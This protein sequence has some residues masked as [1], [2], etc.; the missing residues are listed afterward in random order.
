M[1]YH[2]ELPPRLSFARSSEDSNN[3]EGSPT[4]TNTLSVS[5]PQSRRGSIF[6][7]LFLLRR[8]SG[9]RSKLQLRQFQQRLH[10]GKPG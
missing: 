1:T 7:L 2:A 10:A 6:D 3:N 5:G 9:S 4:N 8:S